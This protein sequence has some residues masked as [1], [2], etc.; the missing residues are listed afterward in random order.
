MPPQNPMTTGRNESLPSPADC[1]MAGISRLQTE[2]AT[3]TPAAN[4]VRM[5][6]TLSLREFFIK[7][8][9]AAPGKRYTIREIK[10]EARLAT[11]GRHTTYEMKVNGFDFDVNTNKVYGVV[12][13]TAD[14]SEYGLHHVTNIWRGTELGFN[15]D[16]TYY[17]SM[18]GKTVTW[19][20][21][22]TANGVY[23]LPVNVTIPAL[24]D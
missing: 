23:V 1:S 11:N 7:K 9:Q 19:I 20:T 16:E 17:T 24:A 12:M 14:G 5:R 4:P 21:Y 10:D 6:C 3:I 22:Y 2:A 15:A 8:T 18:I 13:T